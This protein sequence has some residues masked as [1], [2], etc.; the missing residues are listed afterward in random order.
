[1]FELDI[2]RLAKCFQTNSTRDDVDL[3]LTVW[4]EQQATDT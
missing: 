3:G 2:V 4:F 1:M